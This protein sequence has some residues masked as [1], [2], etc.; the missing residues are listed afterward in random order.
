M[1]EDQ[2][3]KNCTS[4]SGWQGVMCNV[5]AERLVKLLISSTTMRAGGVG[6]SV[7]DMLR[8][9]EDREWQITAGIHSGGLGGGGRAPDPRDHITVR[10]GRTTYH[11]RLH[12]SGNSIVEVTGG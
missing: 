1:D 8:E 5:S 7:K 10:V 2:I 11:V 3:L 9:M 12:S 4:S 6:R